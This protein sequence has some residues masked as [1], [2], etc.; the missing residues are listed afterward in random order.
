MRR[1]LD[2]VLVMFWRAMVARGNK[3]AKE[4]HRLV[5]CCVTLTEPSQAEIAQE[6]QVRTSR[7]EMRITYVYG[8]MQS[9]AKRLY[10][11]RRCGDVQYEY[12]LLISRRVVDYVNSSSRAGLGT[13]FWNRRRTGSLTL[14]TDRWPLTVR[15]S[16]GRRDA[17]RVAV[18]FVDPRHSR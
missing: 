12:H 2:S 8:P 16:N 3:A 13:R 14:N 6:L 9:V 10:T 5:L 17:N 15:H 1:Y 11:A 4:R 18:S 7:Y